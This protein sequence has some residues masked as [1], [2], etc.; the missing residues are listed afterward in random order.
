MQL[1]VDTEDEGEV[2]G[3]V[4]RTAYRVCAEGLSNAAKHGAPGPVTRPP[5]HPER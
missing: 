5:L 3:I 1:Q 4:G 2:G